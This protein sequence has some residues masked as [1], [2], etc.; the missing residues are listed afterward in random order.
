[1]G[2]EVIDVIEAWGLGFHLGNAVKYI[3]RAGAKGDRN[4]DLRKACRYLSRAAEVTD[5]AVFPSTF[6]DNTG[7]LTPEKVGASFNLG[8]NA[9]YAL[10]RIHRSIRVADHA[11]AQRYLRESKRALELEIGDRVADWVPA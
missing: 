3:L 9:H 10:N 8:W 6:V 1:M 4:E 11:T 2:L 7:A 5:I